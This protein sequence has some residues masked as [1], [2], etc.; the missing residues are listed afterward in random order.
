M[1]PFV[2]LHGAW[3]N[4]WCWFQVS[5]QL[6]KI[7]YDNYTLD[8][9]G[10]GLNNGDFREITLRSYVEYVVDFINKLN[11]PVILVGHSMSGIVISQVS[12][13]LSS[14]ISKLV[15]IAAFVPENNG[16]LFDEEQ[17]FNVSNVGEIL[18]P[19]EEEKNFSL[20]GSSD[21][22]K[23]IFYGTCTEEMS[24]LAINKLQ[25]QPLQPF[26][27]KVSLSEKNFGSVAKVYIECLKDEA[28]KIE[29][30]RRMS[31]KLKNCVK[32]VL[33][34][35][36]SPFLSLPNQLTASLIALNQDVANDSD[37]YN[38]LSLKSSIT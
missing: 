8:L 38:E 4:S 25:K 29:D 7:G 17:K 30:Q 20:S 10:H 18:L 28:I 36:H 26:V 21:R 14:K 31:C 34:C 2:F 9:P 3:H 33:D 35:D 12:E 23:H 15:Y 6:N 27:D 19:N 13:V 16:S 24:S 11:R 1:T 5:Y 37:N 22:I 32:I